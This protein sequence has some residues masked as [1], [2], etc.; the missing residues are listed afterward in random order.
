M[1]KIT[2]SKRNGKFFVDDA[3]NFEKNIVDVALYNKYVAEMEV[4]LE[5]ETLNVFRRLRKD[6]LVFY[7]PVEDSSIQTVVVVLNKNKSY[8]IIIDNGTL[9]GEKAS[10]TD[11]MVLYTTKKEAINN[12]AENLKGAAKE[13]FDR[14]KENLS[15]A[16]KRVMESVNPTIKK[17]QEKIEPAKKTAQGLG[18]IAGALLEEI[19]ENAS[20]KFDEVKEKFDNA[21]S[22]PNNE[23]Q[24]GC[25]V[26]RE[27]LMEVRQHIKEIII[28]SVEFKDELA[29][30]NSEIK[31]L[32]R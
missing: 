29:K 16:A 31:N 11:E 28:K 25:Y 2:L 1:A 13:K 6:G 19:A 5:E 18:T 14:A 26:E 17:A 27:K 24:E 4:A 32:I 23:K 8:K 10:L 12:L 30:L 22:T 15:D 20:K 9:Y 21:V 7:R 3:E